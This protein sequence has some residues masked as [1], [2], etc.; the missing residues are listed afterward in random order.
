MPRR[1][2]ASAWQQEQAAAMWRTVAVMLAA[3]MVGM[4]LLVLLVEVLR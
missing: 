2:N 4:A 1:R 3:A